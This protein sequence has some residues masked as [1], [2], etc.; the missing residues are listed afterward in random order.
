MWYTERIFIKDYIEWINESLDLNLESLDELKG[1]EIYCK[2]LDLMFPDCICL[3]NVKSGQNLG[4]REIKHN[5]KIIE[6]AFKSQYIGER[7]EVFKMAGNIEERLEFLQWFYSKFYYRIQICSLLKKSRQIQSMR[8]SE[9]EQAKRRASK[10]EDECVICRHKSEDFKQSLTISSTL[11]SET[12]IREDCMRDALES[13][14]EVKDLV[15]DILD[16]EVERATEH[17]LEQA[18]VS[19]HVD[20]LEKLA[21]VVEKAREAV[22]SHLPR[23]IP[24]VQKAVKCMNS[25]LASIADLS[26]V[27]QEVS[28]AE[29]EEKRKLKLTEASIRSQSIRM[30]K[31]E[32]IFDY[33]S[34]KADRSIS[35]V[36]SCKYALAVMDVYENYDETTKSSLYK[37]AASAL[38]TVD[39][40]I[41]S[42]EAKHDKI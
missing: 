7:H 3:E 27:N 31:A 24:V 21:S 40:M 38:K 10:E 30:Q 25:A 6:K 28:N 26:K 2:F 11:L 9:A 41:H 1:G 35:A 17:Y 18:K 4:E 22:S 42:I 32:R 13:A 16:L 33:K 37:D 8:T 34:S 20:T 14:A 23:F 36:K 29:E 12:S 19:P 5:V 15:E 39:D